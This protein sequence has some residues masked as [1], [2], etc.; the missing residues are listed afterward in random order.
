VIDAG[1][2]VTPQPIDELSLV[3]FWTGQ[4]GDWTKLTGDSVQVSIPA[5]LTDLAGNAAPASSLQKMLLPLGAAVATP[6]FGPAFEGYRNETL[7][8]LAAGSD[9]CPQGCLRFSNSSLSYTDN[10]L[11]L[12]GKLVTA[13][14]TKVK[15]RY[16]LSKQMPFLA[17]STFAVVLP[18]GQSLDPV[19]LDTAS[20]QP[21]EVI[22]SLPASGAEMVGY[23][24]S[25]SASNPDNNTPPHDY[26][27]RLLGLETL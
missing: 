7:T 9:V 19:L 10:K 3:A 22:V 13:G 6:T 23:T 21:E 5:G 15:I 26:D 18:N 24:L 16:Q 11:L 4:P 12:A 17:Q 2:T 8:A 1:G 25:L 20:Q 27:L 14:K